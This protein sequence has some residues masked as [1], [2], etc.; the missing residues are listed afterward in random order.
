MYTGEELPTGATTVQTDGW[1]PGG[2]GYWTLVVT[3]TLVVY[4][5]TISY[6]YTVS[7]LYTG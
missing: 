4:L 3:C 5:Y 2:G 7:Y 1:L 6:L